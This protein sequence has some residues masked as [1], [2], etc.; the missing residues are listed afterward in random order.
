MWGVIMIDEIK[1]EITKEVHTRPL[2]FEADDEAIIDLCY[3]YFEKGREYERNLR[4]I[5]HSEGLLCSWTIY[6]KRKS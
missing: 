2:G 1:E 5:K 4:F 3:E 6:V